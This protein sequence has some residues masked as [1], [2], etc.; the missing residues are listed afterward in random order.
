MV[1]D[2]NSLVHNMPR[3]LKRSKLLP[4]CEGPK[5]HPFSQ[6]PI[7]IEFINLV[8]ENDPVNLSAGGH[9]HVFEALIDS[10][11]YALKVVSQSSSGDRSLTVDCLQ[12]I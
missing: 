10:K 12:I 8:S 5:L 4:D 7:S 9:A 1:N 11:T 6:K 3:A 2:S